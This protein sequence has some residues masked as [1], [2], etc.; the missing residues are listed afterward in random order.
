[1]DWFKLN[2]SAVDIYRTNYS[3]ELYAKLA[4]GIALKQI[5]PLDRLSILDDLYYLTL[6]GQRSSVELVEF[7]AAFKDEKDYTVWYCLSNI[8][9]QYNQLLAG[10]SIIGKYRQ[11]AKE[12]INS[13]IGPYLGWEEKAGEPHLEKLLRSLVIN[14]LVTLEDE[15]ALEHCMKLFK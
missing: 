2:S 13:G 5:A 9:G 4:C 6:S 1:S 7:V 8:L 3:Q 12:L 14:L 11:W 10:T 15:K